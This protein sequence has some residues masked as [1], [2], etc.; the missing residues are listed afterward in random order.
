MLYNTRV[1]KIFLT[2]FTRRNTM[3]YSDIDGFKSSKIILGTDGYG[4][5]IDEN[6]AFTLMDIYREHGG[7]HIDTAKLY[8]GGE[9]EIIVG[10]W[11]KSR[12]R[13]DTIIATKGAHPELNTMH[14][15]R[16]S[17]EEIESDIDSSLFRLNI[18]CIDLYWLHRDNEAFDCIEILESMNSFVKKGKIRKFGCSNWTNARIEKANTYAKSHGLDAFCASQIRFSPAATAPDYVGDTTL[19]EMTASEYEYYK[20]SS[21]AGMAFASQA[22]GFFSKL[23]S[24]GEE[25]LSVKAKERY[26]CGENLEKAKTVAALSQ[27][28]GISPAGA[29]CSALSSL[30]AVDVFPIIGGK[31]DLQIKQSLEGADIILQPNEIKKL[32]SFA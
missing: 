7:N 23:L 20:N 18:D 2:L 5:V 21:V 12:G 9:S 22:K 30:E 26:Y 31:S 13:R 27:K 25:A 17:R 4:E 16:L 6:T 8:C 19:V 3:R 32:I 15:P 11:I 28:Y 10:K 29:V 14:I 24:G 1:R